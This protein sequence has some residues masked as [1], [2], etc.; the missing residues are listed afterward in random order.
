[1]LLKNEDQFL[2]VGGLEI[3]MVK[4]KYLFSEVETAEKIMA[5]WT[6]EEEDNIDIVLLPPK[7]NDA[8]T[9]DEEVDG[10][11]ERVDNRMPNDVS[12][13]IEIQTNI[14]ELEEKVQINHNECVNSDKNAERNEKKEGVLEILE[15][16]E[17]CKKKIIK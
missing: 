15:E 10:N 4:F 13:T 6:D 3:E 7:N 14:P 1:M 12:G 8:V 2:I 11:G 5:E 9:D 16:I 17:K